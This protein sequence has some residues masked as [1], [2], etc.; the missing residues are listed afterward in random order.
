MTLDLLIGNAEAQLQ[1]VAVH[2]VGNKTKEEKLRFSKA[3]LD[4]SSSKIRN[5]LK[6]FFLQSFEGIE[7]YNFTFSNDDLVYNPVYNYVSDIFDHPENLHEKSKDIAQHLYDVSIHPKIKSGDM[8][9]AKL[10]GLYLGDQLTEAIGIFKSENKQSFLKLDRNSDEFYL[11]FDNGINVEKLDKGCL[12]FNVDKG[13]G[14]KVCIVDKSN[15]VTDAQYWRDNFLQ[16]A[17]CNDSFNATREF[18]NIT[19]EFI[20]EQV[21]QE[22]EVTRTD[23][24]DLLNRSMDYFKENE[25]FYKEDFEDNVLQ[26]ENLIDSFRHYDQTYQAENKLAVDDHFGISDEAV[27]KQSRAFKSVIKLDKNFH[28]YVHGDKTLIEQGVDEDGRKYYKLFYEN[29]Q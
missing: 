4:I 22:F 14:Y 3:K 29:E 11:D 24:I 12:I 21:P 17:P 7:F 10:S 9:V 18:M 15:R 1:T 2:Q 8:F 19:K 13:D 25:A 16:L 20:K 27:K 6:T 28:I 26:D 23:K 5:L